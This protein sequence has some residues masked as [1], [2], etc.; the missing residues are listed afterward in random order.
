MEKLE[1]LGLKKVTEFS[2]E[3]TRERVCKCQKTSEYGWK[4]KEHILGFAVL[5]LFAYST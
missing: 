5:E 4:K 3:E 1:R 2:L